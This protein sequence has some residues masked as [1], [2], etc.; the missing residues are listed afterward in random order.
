MCK[1]EGDVW[2]GIEI[3]HCSP[4]V[5]HILDQWGKYKYILYISY[6]CN[7]SVQ[8]LQALA[9]LGDVLVDGKRLV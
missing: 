3:C 4:R 2:I 7:S 9:V 8:C 1:V 6:I 5:G